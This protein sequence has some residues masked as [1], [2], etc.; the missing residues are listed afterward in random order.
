MNENN[1]GD[2]S[3]E[4]VFSIIDPQQLRDQELLNRLSKLINEMILHHFDQLIQLLYRIDVDEMKLKKILKDHP[5]E[6]A[7]M[8][9][10]QL[11]IE[12]QVQK[13][14]LRQK[15]ENRLNDAFDEESW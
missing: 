6:D 9:I 1:Q 10:A 2:F 15:I 12:R 13:I 7:G 4:T 5:A 8:I 14:N 3:V 11:I